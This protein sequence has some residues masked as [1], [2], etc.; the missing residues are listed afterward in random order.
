MHL[1]ET[2]YVQRRTVVVVKSLLGL[3]E[4]FSLGLQFI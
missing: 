1:K 4:Y 3:T 2:I